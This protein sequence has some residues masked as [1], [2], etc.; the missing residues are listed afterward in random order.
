[1][2]LPEGCLGAS[3]G[4]AGICVP[5]RQHGAL[6]ALPA[7][8]ALVPRG[9]VLAERPAWRPGP[10]AP[11]REWERWDEGG[12]ADGTGMNAQSPL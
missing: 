3:E 2:P 12:G 5:G 6:L 8:A 7:A 1:M 10:A 4:R 9:S 11:G